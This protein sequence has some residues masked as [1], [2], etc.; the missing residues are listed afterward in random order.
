MELAGDVAEVASN[1]LEADGD[2]QAKGMRLFKQA[3]DA[4]HEEEKD[5]KDFDT[6]M[7]APLLL[8]AEQDKLLEGLRAEGFFDLFAFDAQRGEW[9]VTSIA[10]GSEAAAATKV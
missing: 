2:L 8:A 5:Q 3:Y 6:L 4:F 7:R 10:E 1:V 9:V